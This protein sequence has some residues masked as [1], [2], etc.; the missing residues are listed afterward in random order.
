M[1][2]STGMSFLFKSNGSESAN[3]DSDPGC[4]DP[5]NNR[6]ICKHP[7]L[8]R[9][10]MRVNVIFVFLSVFFPVIS[11]GKFQYTSST[12]YEI[13]LPFSAA[14]VIIEFRPSFK[15]EGY[16]LW[17]NVPKRADWARKPD[18]GKN[19]WRELAAVV[20][21]LEPVSKGYDSMACHPTYAY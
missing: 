19:H 16:Q 4:Q 17:S 15:A 9:F 3:I 5:R 20:T 8:R 2:N 21:A 10:E 11:A 1:T 12:D 13:D 7:L 6:N 18:H 14:E